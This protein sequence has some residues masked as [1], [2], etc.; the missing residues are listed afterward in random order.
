MLTLYTWTT[1]NG[2]K[3][4]IMLEEIGASY[5]VRPVNL[6]KKEQFAPDFLEISPNNKIPALVDEPK[7]GTRR[8]IFETGA[9]LIYLAEQSGKLLASEGSKRDETLEWLFWATSGLAPMLGQWNY[10]A[11]RAEEKVPA[12][13]TRFTEEAVRLFNILEKRLSEVEFLAGDYSIADIGAFTWTQAILPALKN[14]GPEGLTATRAIDRWLHQINARPTVA[15]G[16]Q[17]PK[18]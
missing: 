9:I 12:A 2:R 17:V 15:R 3:A 5:D 7:A 14:S 10:F 6:G 16:L 18:I 13:T 4:S 1:P 11:R 8:V